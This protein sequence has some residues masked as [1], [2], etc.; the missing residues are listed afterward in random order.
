MKEKLAAGASYHLIIQDASDPF[1]FEG[2]QLVLLPSHVLYSNSH[3]TMMH[4][5]LKPEKGILVFQAETYNIPSNL[6]EIRKWRRDLSEIG[7]EKVRYGSISIGTYPTGQ[8][9]FYVAHTEDESKDEKICKDE[10]TCDDFSVMDWLD[11][12]AISQHF[13]DIPGKTKYYHPRI[14]KR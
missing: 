12:S 13:S 9:G 7:Y 3:F 5:L 2:G 11:W 14:H 8:I 4:D 1:F 10:S 6:E